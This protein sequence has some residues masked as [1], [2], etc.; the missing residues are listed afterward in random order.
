MRDA[1]RVGIAKFILRDTLHL[2]AIE[3]IG[4]ALVLTMMRFAD[5]LVELK[6]LALPPVKDIRKNELDMAKA[7][8]ESLAADWEPEKY[9]DEYREN[10]MRII[11]GKVKGKKVVL[12]AAEEPRQAQ[13]I[14]LMERLRRSLDE[15]SGKAGAG[16]RRSAAK[17]LKLSSAKRRAPRKRSTRAA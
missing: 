4:D 11:Q 13:V 6:S 12:D 9:T 17:S 3:S 16:G 8:V 1:K 10:L 14:D 5:E 7:L 15:R 2:A